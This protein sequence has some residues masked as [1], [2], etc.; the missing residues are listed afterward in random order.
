VMSG[1]YKIR[2]R[3]TSRSDRVST[4]QGRMRQSCSRSEAEVEGVGE[5]D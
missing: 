2:I 3:I 5:K 4:Q 1:R